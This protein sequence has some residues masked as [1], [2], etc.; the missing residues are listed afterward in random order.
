MGAEVDPGKFKHRVTIQELGGR[1][2]YGQPLPD[3]WVDVATRLRANIRTLTGREFAT[4]G[5]EASEVTTSIRLRYRTGI[6]A[7]MRVVHGDTIYDIRA[8]LPNEEDRR[9]VDLA[10]ATG[11]NDG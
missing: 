11:A 9:Y 2:D 3:G 6:Q 10:C 1:D 4:S 7:G 8:V 5:S